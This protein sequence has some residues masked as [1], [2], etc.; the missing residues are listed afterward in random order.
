[1]PTNEIQ[2][3]DIKPLIEI[4]EYSF[5]YF[6]A[7]IAL[8]IIVV[9]ALSYLLFRWFKNRNKFNMRAE[10]LKLLKAI[11]FDEAKQDAYRI[12]HYGMTFQDDS[13]RHKKAYHEL[14][15]ALEEY[16]Y[17]KSVASFSDDVKHKYEIYLGLIDV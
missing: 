2:L 11:R 1:M 14:V 9:V 15:E 13:E 6:M 3:H 5:Y 12:T 16:K 4:Q 8:V 10:H 7:L 17:K